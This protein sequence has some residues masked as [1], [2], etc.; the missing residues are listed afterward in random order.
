VGVPTT[1]VV[2]EGEF[3]MVKIS[4]SLEDEDE[5]VT[6]GAA[7]SDPSIYDSAA[8]I[9]LISVLVQPRSIVWV[10]LER[11]KSFHSYF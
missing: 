6:V 7:L 9:M 11:A 3:V 10:G 4:V 1:D 2:L 5:V 8:L